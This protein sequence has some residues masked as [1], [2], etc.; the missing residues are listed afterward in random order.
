[1][2][3]YNEEL[4]TKKQNDSVNILQMLES[5]I[6]E[7]VQIEKEV[8]KK[9]PKLFQQR[10][11]RFMR[12]RAASHNVKRIPKLRRPKNVESK[13]R[14]K[15]FA[16]RRKVLFTNH[17]RI[18]KKNQR[19]A[20]KDPNKCVLHKWFAKRFKLERS[21]ESEGL[22]QV[23][24]YNNT[25][26]QRNLYRQTRYGCAYLSLA[27]TIAVR[28]EGDYC[29]KLLAKL[30][31]LSESIS[32]FTF[33]ARTLETDRYEVVVHLFTPTTDA[34][35]ADHKE[36]KV[37][38]EP[39]SDRE[40]ICPMFV[41]NRADHMIFW[42]PRKHVDRIL[43]L[44]KSLDD[45]L[46]FTKIQPCDWTR[47]RLIGPKSREEAMKIAQDPERHKQAISDVDQRLAPRRTLGLSIGRFIDEQDA[48]FT[49]YSTDPYAV[50]IVFRKKAGRMLWHKLIKNKSHLVGGKRD[51]D[52]L[53]TGNCFELIPDHFLH[54]R[55]DQTPVISG[56]N[57]KK[58]VL[59]N[60]KKVA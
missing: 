29:M 31:I 10:L 30:D 33:S 52:T 43:E 3:N 59:R 36:K 19:H 22:E 57:S 42:L 15:L 37:K 24:L 9:F 16:H 53:T 18:L 45:S 8:K 50:D 60:Q 35:Q 6:S 48:S 11:P 12:R 41:N 27:D 1:M 14:K 26:N 20:Y 54:K 17:K 25:K 4:K 2:D 23:P 44:Y 49:Y 21:Q 40:Y 32:G 5:R 46:K 34:D 7:I 39:S 38:L 55:A 28:L 58:V 56:S 13:D 47:V 51:V